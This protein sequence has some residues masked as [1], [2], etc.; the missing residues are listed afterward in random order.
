MQLFIQGSTIHT[1]DVSEE[2]QVSDVKE[3]LSTLE[4]VS[5]E[6]Q[7]LYYGGLPLDDDVFVCESVPDNGTL[8]LAV[9]L[10]GG[11]WSMYTILTN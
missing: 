10:L 8:S 7:I 11:M 4:E 1:L 6:D 5:S 2:T 3:A 9:R